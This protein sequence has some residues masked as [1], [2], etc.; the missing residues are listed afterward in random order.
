MS[1]NRHMGAFLKRRQTTSLIVCLAILLQLFVPVWASASLSADA[2]PWAADICRSPSP[3]KAPGSAHSLKHCLSCASASDASAPPAA[4][5]QLA[6]L[7]VGKA[8]RPDPVYAS[9]AAAAH[10]HPAQP[11]APPALS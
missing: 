8:L 11:R 5:Q 3:A 4:P 2:S 9:V 10:W 6:T 1:Y 7:P